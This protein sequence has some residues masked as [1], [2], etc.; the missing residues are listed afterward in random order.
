M[1]GI[2][3]TNR[4]QEVVAAVVGYTGTELTTTELKDLYL[5]IDDTRSHDFQMPYK[6]GSLRIIHNDCIEDIKTE[7]AGNLLMSFDE[8][9]DTLDLLMRDWEPRLDNFVMKLLSTDGSGYEANGW[10]VFRTA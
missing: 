5:T 7:E 10:W 8:N 9:N 4:N 1:R 6:G 3:M 2:N